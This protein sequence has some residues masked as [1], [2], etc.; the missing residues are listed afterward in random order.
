MKDIKGYED[1]YAITK[2]GK[3]WSY[4]K[5]NR[6]KYGMWL[7]QSTIKKKRISGKEYNMKTVGL[8]KNAKQ[9]RVLAHRLVAESFIP[10]PENKPQVN[11][12]DGNPLNNKVD[13]LEWTTSFENMQ[14]GQRNGLLNQF[15]Q[16][17]IDARSESGK[18]MGPINSITHRR[19]FTIVEADCIKKI[20]EIGRK[21]CWAI[22]KAY[23]CSNLTISNIC[24]Y[25]TYLVEVKHD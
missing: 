1:L 5:T 12:K 13:N 24:N 15:T 21:S 22:A 7:K 3:V 8:H 16:K 23:H 25:K 6:N 14:H 18:R 20:H 9:K 11:H 10:N 2:D 19:I 4:P 17:Q